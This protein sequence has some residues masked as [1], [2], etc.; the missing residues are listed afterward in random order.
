MTGLAKV[1]ITFT[2]HSSP[3]RVEI[4]AR[5]SMHWLRYCFVNRKDRPSN[6]PHALPCPTLPSPSTQLPVTFHQTDIQTYR[7]TYRQPTSSRT[8]L[9]AAEFTDSPRQH[10]VSKVV[11]YF[12]ATHHHA[13]SPALHSTPLPLPPRRK[14]KAYRNATDA[15]GIHRIADTPAST[16]PPRRQQSSSKP[17][18]G[19]WYCTALYRATAVGAVG[20][21]VRVIDAAPLR[22]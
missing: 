6:L 2:L 14:A 21:S 8:R 11:L 9:P 19:T 4:L 18:I 3:A 1:L 10:T 22:P 12:T 5:S 15:K 20:Q 17:E 7:H 13:I 16:H